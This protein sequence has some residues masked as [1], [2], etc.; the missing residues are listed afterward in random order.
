MKLA[1]VAVLAAALPLALAPQDPRPDPATLHRA[2]QLS[3]T[4]EHH[5]RLQQ[6]LG[7]WDVAVHTALPGGDPREDRGKLVAAS[8][9]GGR[10]M[11]LNFTLELQ[12]AKLDAVLILGFDTLRQVYTASWRDSLSTWSVDCSGAPTAETPDVLTMV[13][14]VADARDPTGRPLRLVLELAKDKPI[15]MRTFETIGGKEV[16][17]QVQRWTKK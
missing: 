13:G 17:V 9:L 6:V 8:I 5:T 12:D 16:E 1:A 7:E 14:T 11:V 10:Y 2:K 4:T 3:L 15:T